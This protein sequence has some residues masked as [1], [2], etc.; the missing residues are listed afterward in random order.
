MKIKKV[1]YECTN[2][3]TTLPKGKAYKCFTDEYPVKKLGS[4]KISALLREHKKNNKK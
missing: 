1:C 4:A 3:D 2:F